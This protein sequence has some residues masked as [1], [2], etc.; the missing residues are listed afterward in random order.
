MHFEP[1][2]ENEIPSVPAHAPAICRPLP[3]LILSVRMLTRLLLWMAF[4]GLTPAGPELVEWVTHYVQEGDFADAPDH[5]RSPAQESEH[6]CAV[7]CHSCGCHGPSATPRFTKP[8][9]G[10]SL[11]SHLVIW[12]HP[13]LLDLRDFP[14]PPTPPPN[15]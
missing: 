3:V 8:N 6:G 9:S 14:Q 1:A 2:A 12:P 5:S 4:I 13:G 7:L 10:I 15:S 11:P